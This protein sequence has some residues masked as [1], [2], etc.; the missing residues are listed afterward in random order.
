MLLL[1]RNFV[2]QPRMVEEL[3]DND[4]TASAESLKILAA[5]VIVAAMS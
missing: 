2:I 3:F 4:P 5:S 1:C